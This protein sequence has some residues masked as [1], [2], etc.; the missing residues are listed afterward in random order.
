MNFNCWYLFVLLEYIYFFMKNQ[1]IY[2]Y[3]YL[4]GILINI[5]FNYLLKYIFLIPKPFIDTSLFHLKLIQN[6][7]SWDELGF[8]SLFSTLAFYSFIYF[9]LIY[10]NSW[11]NIVFV[12]FI[13]IGLFY[14]YKIKQHSIFQIFVGSIIGI[15]SSFLFIFLSKYFLKG[16][17][18]HNNKHELIIN[19]DITPHI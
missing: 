11:I 8:P 19:T 3:F 9:Y 6:N 12:F 10:S 5:L 4:L 15:S 18:K 16:E 7:Y 2:S 1:Y 13:I 14:F 17:L